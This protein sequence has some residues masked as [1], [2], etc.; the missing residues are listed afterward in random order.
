MGGLVRYHP[1]TVTDVKRDWEMK[2]NYMQVYGSGRRRRLYHNVRYKFQYSFRDLG[3]PITTG[4][5]SVTV[6]FIMLACSF[7]ATLTLTLTLSRS[8]YQVLVLARYI[9]INK[10]TETVRTCGIPLC[11]ESSKFCMVRDI[12][13]LLNYQIKWLNFD[14]GQIGV[15]V[16]FGKSKL[17]FK[18]HVGKAMT[19]VS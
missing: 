19:A 5:D 10:L 1:V 9:M 17:K 7:S 4:S 8:V 3:K 14:S 13:K 2:M 11:V 6:T 12:W 16:K 15:H 18:L